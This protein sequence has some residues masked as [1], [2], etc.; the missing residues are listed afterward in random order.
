MFDAPAVAQ[1]GE[2]QT[3]GPLGIAALLGI[4]LIKAGVR[5]ERTL[6]KRPFI[7]G[8][9]EVGVDRSRGTADASTTPEQS[10]AT[11]EPPGGPAYRA[12]QIANAGYA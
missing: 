9:P 8:V 12:R 7:S 1:H 11:N 3:A 4:G 6:A 2:A 10:W 5:S